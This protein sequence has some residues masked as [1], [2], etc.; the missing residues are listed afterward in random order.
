MLPDVVNEAGVV[1]YLDGRRFAVAVF[2]RQPV[3]QPPP[4]S[5]PRGAVG[6]AIGEV[7]RLAVEHLAAIS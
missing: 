1:D 4:A 5:Q 3:D 7:A 2:T 6:R